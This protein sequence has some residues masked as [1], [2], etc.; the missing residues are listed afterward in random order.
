MAPATN[1]CTTYCGR[2]R[3]VFN[4]PWLRLLIFTPMMGPARPLAGL[5]GRI[6][7][8]YFKG[9]S[10]S[11]GTRADQGVCPTIC[12]EFAARKVSDINRPRLSLKADCDSRRLVP[13]P[14]DLVLHVS[15]KLL[16]SR[17]VRKCS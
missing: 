17:W 14:A 8:H 9:N 5:S 15:I 3:L 13:C 6:V 16:K 10:G 12:A 2:H 1:V 11:R 4:P 7:I